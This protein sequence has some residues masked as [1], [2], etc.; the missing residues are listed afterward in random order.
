EGDFGRGRKVRCLQAGFLEK[1]TPGRLFGRFARLDPSAGKGE[2]S[3]RRRAPPSDEKKTP[4]AKHRHRNGVDNAWPCCILSH[5]L[6]STARLRR[7][8]AISWN[9]HREMEH[10]RTLC[11]DEHAER[12]GGP[13]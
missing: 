3:A 1:L 9:Q 5:G 6:Y 8:N 13:V 12:C 4:V 10:V 7:G 2:L 11:A